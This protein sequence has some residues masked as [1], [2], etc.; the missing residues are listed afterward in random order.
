MMKNVL[1]SD[2]IAQ[3]CVTKNKYVL[4]YEMKHT[5][6]AERDKILAY[7]DGKID[8][9]YLDAMRNDDDSFFE[10]DSVGEAE[11]AL[12]AFPSLK[13][14]DA[15]TGDPSLYVY[16]CLYNANGDLFYDNYMT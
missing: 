11:D 5:T 4:Y 7:Y 8:S 6:D 13:E 10:Y 1:I 16:C 15:M 2:I 9:E 12:E 14:I 3:Y